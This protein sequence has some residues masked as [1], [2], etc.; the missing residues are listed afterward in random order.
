MNTYE[1][2]GVFF[3]KKNEEKKTIVHYLKPI[4]NKNG[5]G[6]SGEKV[7]L[8]EYVDIKKGDLIRFI[9]DLGYDGKA[10]IK[11]VEKVD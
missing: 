8:N 1:V 7:F 2:I 3:Y 9:F 6:F 5:S 4:E 10:Y 11:S